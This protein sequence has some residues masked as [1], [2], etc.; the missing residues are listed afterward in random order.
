[1]NDS[2]T[3]FVE[4]CRAEGYTSPLTRSQIKAVVYKHKVPMPTW[5]L[6]VP[7]R[8]LASGKYEVQELTSNTAPA[9]IVP[10]VP[11]T[12]LTL[13]TQEETPMSVLNYQ[14]SVSTTATDNLVPA[15]LSHYVPYGHFSDISKIIESKR[16]YPVYITG[17]SGNGKTTMVEQVC[18]K[19]NREYVRVN[20]TAQ[21]DEDDLLGGFRL[22]DGSTVW[23][24]GAVITAMK[25]G[26][27]LLLDEVDL[28]S[29][30]IM[31]LQPV[32]EGKGIFLKKI[33]KYVM[34][35]PGFNVFATANTKGQAG[36]GSERFAGTN[37][38]NEAFLE[39]FYVMYEQDYPSKAVEKRIVLNIMK[40]NGCRDDEFADNLVKWAEII[41][42]TFKEGGVDDIITTRRLEHIVLNYSIFRDRMKAVTDCVG[43]FSPDSR[44]SFVNL[45]TKIDASAI[46]SK[47][48]V[49][50]E[51]VST[52]AALN[53]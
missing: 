41:R 28:G 23:Q 18:S 47:P 49:P 10:S 2:M 19:L 21:T 36:E 42:K 1:M 39:R 26:A 50:A 6:N 7:T 32:L 40:D 38:L 14:P 12:I 52:E 20:I 53:A 3:K 11:S 35:A 30:K 33:N 13:P 8:R 43:R 22:V 37:I 44:D 16:F 17:L 51:S 5:I 25:R 24:D 46:A 31:C 27:I 34:P 29:H 9:T 45:Y 4:A 15:K 48:E